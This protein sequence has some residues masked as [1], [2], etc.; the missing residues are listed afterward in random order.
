MKHCCMLMPERKAFTMKQTILSPSRMSARI[1]S[2]SA[3]TL[4]LNSGKRKSWAAATI[5]PWAARAAFFACQAAKLGL[6]TA[7]VGDP[8]R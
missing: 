7:V 4:C 6:K 8:C 1:C 2:F 3:M 5:S